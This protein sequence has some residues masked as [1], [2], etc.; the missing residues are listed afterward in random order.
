MQIHE[1]NN[2]TGT[3]GSTD[4]LAIDTGEETFKVGANNLGVTTPMTQAEAEAGTV[5]DPRVITPK[6]LH[7]Y[8]ENGIEDASCIVLKKASVSTLPITIRE[9]RLTPN[10]IVKPKDYIL[11]N[12]SVM[13]SDWEINTDTSG[14]ATISGTISGTTDITLFFTLKTN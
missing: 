7:D 2:Y 8:V 1:L 6:V 10:H 4:Y 13:S 14:Q 3:P 11:S 5:T 9:S 12:P